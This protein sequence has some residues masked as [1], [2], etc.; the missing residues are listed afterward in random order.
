MNKFSGGKVMFKE[1]IDGMND[2][3]L[4]K[5]GM[6]NE[7]KMKYLVASILAGAYIGVGAI[8]LFFMGGP[9]YAADSPF[10]NLITGITFGV[11]LVIVIWGGSELFTSNVMIMAFSALSK[12]TTWKDTMILWFWCYLGNLIGAIMFSYLIFF[13]GIL[14]DISMEGFT[15]ATATDKMNDGFIN[16]LVQ[17]ILCN[18]LVC[19]AVWTSARAKGDAAKLVLVFVLIF[20]FVAA[21]FEHSIAN[22]SIL[23]IALLHSSVETVTVSGFIYNLIPV[24]IGNII[25][26]ALFVSAIYY[27]LSQPKK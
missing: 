27:Y 15:V 4:D 14:S 1:T 18:W 5:L 8:V 23:G 11:A 20:A 26:G 24:T 19:L 13:S 10:V 9:L 25:G 17:G 3:A 21:G 6:Y 7:S 22:M 12:V 2:K 16:L